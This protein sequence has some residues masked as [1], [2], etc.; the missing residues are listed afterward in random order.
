VD[1]LLEKGTVLT[2]LE[3]VAMRKE[4]SNL[5]LQARGIEGSYRLL[6]KS[7]PEITEQFHVQFGL[8]SAF[9]AHSLAASI[10][11]NGTDQRVEAII[12]YNVA[13]TR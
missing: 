11:L 8:P 12:L 3:S 4:T 10:S 2:G 1:W 9:L 6:I 7:Y 5:G 13:P